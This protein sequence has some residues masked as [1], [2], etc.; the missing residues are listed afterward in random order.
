MASE[1]AHGSPGRVV[2][3]IAHG[4]RF[5]YA[6]SSQSGKAAVW[7]RDSGPL[8]REAGSR[9]GRIHIGTS[10]LVVPDTPTAP[11]SDS[12]RAERQFGA[13]LSYGRVRL[14]EHCSR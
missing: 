14:G 6:E 9:V 12:R 7:V 2:T 13:S 10:A 8:S 3:C 1:D 11:C 5:A 4:S